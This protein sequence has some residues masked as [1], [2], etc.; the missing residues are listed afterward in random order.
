MEREPWREQLDPTA[1]EAYGAIGTQLRVHQER[2]VELEV[3]TKGEGKARGSV[4]DD[5]EFGSPCA[6]CSRQNSQPKW[7]MKTR[8]TGLSFQRSAKRTRSPRQSD[9]SIP[10]SLVAVRIE[11]FLVR[12]RSTEV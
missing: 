4:S 11:P 12:N 10:E 1:P 8:T 7:R 2:A 9:S 3:L 5:D 6:T